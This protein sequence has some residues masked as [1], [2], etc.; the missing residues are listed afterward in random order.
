MKETRQDDRNKTAIGINEQTQT[1]KNTVKNNTK[2]ERRDDDDE[3][4]IKKM[5]C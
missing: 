5:K 1:Q 2:R 3:Q 4:T